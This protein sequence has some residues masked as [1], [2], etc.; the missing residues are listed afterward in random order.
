MARRI[1]KVSLEAKM[2]V[3]EEKYIESFKPFMMTS[4][5][6]WANG[7]TFAEICEKTDVF[8]GMRVEV[9]V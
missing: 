5:L 6:D 7:A 2:E 8:E 1:A 3:D 9:Q 4:V